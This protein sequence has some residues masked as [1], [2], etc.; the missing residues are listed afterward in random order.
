[1]IF[2]GFQVRNLVPRAFPL[3]NGWGGKRPPFPAPPIVKGKALGTRLPSSLIRQ[4]N[5]TQNVLC[6][7]SDKNKSF[8]IK[9]AVKSCH[10]KI[11]CAVEQLSWY[12]KVLS[13]WQAIENS[14][15]W[16]LLLEL[17]F[18][19]KFK[20]FRQNTCYKVESF[21]MYSLVCL[22]FLKRR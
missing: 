9:Y 6:A 12:L 2:R 1:M 3:K 14:A 10:F 13:N 21:V 18:C 17:K 22:G 15:H 4:L 8:N 7:T 11:L 5:F 19:L 16:K 20:R